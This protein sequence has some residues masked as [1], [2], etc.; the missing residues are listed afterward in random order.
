MFLGEIMAKRVEVWV[1]EDGTEFDTELECRNY[2]GVLISLPDVKR[3]VIEDLTKALLKLK[4]LEPHQEKVNVG[5]N[6]QFKS[7]ISHID[8]LEQMITDIGYDN[9]HEDY[10]SSS[11]NC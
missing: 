6:E 5:E 1:A 7:L 9:S 10:Y 11:Y 3:E 8:V 2:E 4:G